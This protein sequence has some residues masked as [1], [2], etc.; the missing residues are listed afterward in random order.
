MKCFFFII[1][2]NTLSSVANKHFCQILT[3]SVKGNNT[4]F[5]GCCL[6]HGGSLRTL[7][8]NTVLQQYTRIWHRIWC[9]CVS[10]Y[11][12]HWWW[13]CTGRY[14]YKEHKWQIIIIRYRLWNLLDQILCVCVHLIYYT[15]TNAL[16][17]YNSLKSLH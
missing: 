2:N 11:I 13:P 7:I 4:V 15:Q 5:S 9:T 14:T 10:S 1:L 12:P 3:S 8:N 16:L 17:Y 6:C